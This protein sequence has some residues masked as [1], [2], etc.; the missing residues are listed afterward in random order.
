MKI[1]TFQTR[2]LTFIHPLFSLTFQNHIN[3]YYFMFSPAPSTH[4]YEQSVAQHVLN[5]QMTRM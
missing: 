1:V 3:S 2:P 5:L 4:C